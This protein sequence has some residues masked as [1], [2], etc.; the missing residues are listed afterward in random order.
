[1]KKTLKFLS[2]K[3]I[4]LLIGICLLLGLASL[5]FRNAT[6]DDDLYLFE[7]SIMTE[8]LSQG[9]WIGDYAVGTHGFLFKLP[10]ALIFLLTGPSLA[11]ATVWNILLGCV[12]LFLFYKILKVYFVKSIYP[13]L[14]TLLLLCNFQFLLNLPTYMREIP[15]LIGVLLLMYALVKR[16]S[17]WLIGL[18]SVIILDGKEYVFFMLL[19]ALAIY[20]LIVEWKGVNSKTLLNYL[21]A[22]F[23]TLLP[24]IIFF[25]LMIFTSIIPLNM[26][27]LSVIPGV[28]KGG[29]EY[30]VDHFTLEKATTNRIKEQAPSLQRDTPKEESLVKKL[31]NVVVSYIGKILYPRSFSFLS[32][33]KIIFFPALLTSILLFKNSLKRRE[34][35]FTSFALILWSYIL[36]FV[37][38]AS[39]DRYLFPI[40]P[41]VTF[42][43]LLFVRDLVK[44]RKRFI[45]VL[46]VTALLTFVGLLFEVDYIAI[47]IVL[48][49]L[50]L[51]AYISYLFYHGKIKNLSTPLLIFLS[52]I[53][54]SV[55]AF[56]FYNNGQ[57]HYYDLWGKDYEVSKVVGLFKDEEGIMINDPGWNMLINVYR[58][59]NE[60]SP[61]WKWELQD[62]IPRKNNLKSF[63]KHSTYLPT[64]IAI[65]NDVK[66]VNEYDIEKVALIL[67]TIEDYTFPFNHK[68]EK[69]M[70]ADWL[71]LEEIVNLKN[72][73]LYIFKVIK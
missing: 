40:L 26:Y 27:A 50:V 72:K 17:Y 33:A 2:S 1:M 24:T 28:T 47:K 11:I 70:S 43:F 8:A 39:F 16:R 21:K 46:V 61:E 48:N 49:V 71:E 20:I 37:L 29:V 58:G 67:S 22:S 73:D 66:T 55:I 57:Y 54:F 36:I 7:T 44:E 10:V 25:L 23:Q 51:L 41:V 4:Y 62:W 38:R 15:V 6:L 65:G 56:F 30:Q 34:Y 35:V 63:G 59:D 14:G 64:G 19:P 60:Y 45:R 5:S 9:E 31:F 13:L 69:Y 18:A 32:I 12:A 52:T 3:G 53:T 68:L 42:F